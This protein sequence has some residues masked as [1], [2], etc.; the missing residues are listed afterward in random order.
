MKNLAKWKMDKNKEQNGVEVV[1]DIDEESGEKISFIIARTG[2]SNKAYNAL[3][4]EKMKTIRR[5]AELGLVASE[6]KLQ[7]INREVF[8][9]T[10][11][12]G[13]SGIKGE[14]GEVWEF[15]EENAIKLLIEIPDIYEA[16]YRKSAEFETFR[17]T[18][19]E[20]E[21]KN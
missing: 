4:D 15:N 9:K 6:E 10:I 18:A 12:K 13:W 11:L 8:A 2:G 14:N 19:L 20:S 17:Q 16:L 5:D 1:W 7:E 3:Y 21:A